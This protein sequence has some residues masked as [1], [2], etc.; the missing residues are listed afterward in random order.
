MMVFDRLQ[1]TTNSFFSFFQ[2][3][4]RGISADQFWR[5]ILSSGE[6][7]FRKEEEEEEVEGARAPS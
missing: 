3:K 4:Q 2:L 5:G 6:V 1:D 7:R